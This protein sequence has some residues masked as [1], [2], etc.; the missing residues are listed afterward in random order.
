MFV[1]PLRYFWDSGGSLTLVVN[2]FLISASI[3]PVLRKFAS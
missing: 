3:Y 1:L 2:L